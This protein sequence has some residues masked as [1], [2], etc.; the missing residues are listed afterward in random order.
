MNQAVPHRT[1]SGCLALALGLFA[2]SG[3]PLTQALEQPI[4]IPDAQFREGDLPGLPPLTAAEINAG[5]KPVTPAVI[6]A[7]VGNLI[8]PGEAARSVTGHASTDSVAVGVR[9]AE[10]GT[11]YWVLPTRS[12]DATSGGALEWGFRAA[13]ARGVPPGRH[14]LLFAAFDAEGRSG[15]QLE[16][17]LCLAPEIPDNG[18][19]CIPSQA[20]PE[21]VVSLGWD[22]PVDLDLRVITPSGKLTDSK[23]PTTAPLNKEGKPDPE[24][25]EIGVIA[26][27]SF[28]GCVPDG[29]RRESLVF[30]NKPPSGTYLVYVNLY[31]ACGQRA[32]HF[33]VSLHQPARG[34]ERGTFTT[35]ETFR[36]A[37]QLEAVHANGGSA[38]GLF[39]TS[40]RVR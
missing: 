32:V 23:A 5:E 26:Y 40:F 33:D 9:F 4:R 21:L 29:R 24:A 6:T 38:L 37:G 16:L 8:P 3:E 27:D 10:L 14:Q 20:P 35:R 31:D 12:A 18:N 34:E 30:Q 13:F 39:V 25:E 28:A 11:G 19:A 22:A 1:W 7:S 15:N 2:C 36:Q 17:T